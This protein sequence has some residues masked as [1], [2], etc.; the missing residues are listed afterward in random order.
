MRRCR[1]EP[2]GTLQLFGGL[3]C[4]K[5]AERKLVDIHFLVDKEVEELLHMD[6]M[7]QRLRVPSVASIISL[8][9]SRRS[10]STISHRSMANKIDGQMKLFL[11]EAS[12]RI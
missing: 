8:H 9:Q 6:T 1:Y 11:R 12:A 4:L 7:Q 5:A 10:M 3:T 2:H